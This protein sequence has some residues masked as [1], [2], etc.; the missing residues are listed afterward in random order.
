[1]EKDKRMNQIMEDMLR[2]YVRTKPSKWKDYLH[3]VEFSYNNG[4]QTS[5]KLSPF[6]VLYGRKCMTPI[7]WDSLVDKLMVGPEMLQ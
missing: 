3:L 2:M 1:M 4:H 6:E 7:G 5:A